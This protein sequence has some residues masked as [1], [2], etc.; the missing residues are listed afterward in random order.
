M[1]AKQ[2]DIL[3]N[4]QQKIFW[5][6]QRM[7]PLML[8]WWMALVL[9]G[10]VTTPV[11]QAPA[12][13]H[14]THG[15][16]RVSLPLNH[17]A[18]VLRLRSVKGGEEYKL[19]HQPDQGPFAFGLWIPAGEYEVAGLLNP[20]GSKYLSTEVRP[21]RLTDLGAL[22]WLQIGG[23]ES[24]LL[25]IQHP[26]AVAETQR[27]V[28]QLRPYL[29]ASQSIAWMPRVPPK[30]EKSQMA[31][32][33][34]GLIAD[35]LMQYQRHVNMPPLNQQL[36]ESK[37]IEEFFRRAVAL[38]P[39]KADEPATDADSNLYY[40]ADLG[41]IRV[42]RRDGQWTSIDTGTLQSITAVEASGR[43]LVAGT[44]QGEIR[45]SDNGQAWRVLSKFG[46]SEAILDID[47][48]NNRWLVVTARLTP[49]PMSP[50]DQW[51]DQVKVYT[52]TQDDP[53]ELTLLREIEL[54]EKAMFAFGMG[55]RGQ[56]A[57]NAYY[58]N[59]QSE[60]LKLDL[61]TLQWSAIGLAHRI[62]GYNVSPKTGVLTAYR[63]QGAFSKLSVSNDHGATWRS[64]DTP[65]Y[66]IYDVYFESPSKGVATRW[67]SGA[68]TATIEFMEYLAVENRWE[69]THEAPSGCVRIL[70]DANNVQ[71]F[72]VTSGNS[73][74][75]Y[76][77]GK[78]MAEFAVY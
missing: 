39:P 25:P 55:V 50:A 19:I 7:K 23:Y 9:T 27:A 75:T 38:M 22:I 53:T 2:H 24:V 57:G 63:N 56:H 30:P 16:V 68:F 46:S 26:E 21:G 36:K 6:G 43:R 62:S 58:I 18:D 48:I 41:Q 59:R 49:L 52:S 15:F 3:T 64:A 66:T 78:W 20:D 73:I 5:G 72:C 11:T 60:L 1:G 44:A 67:S 61:D 69:K 32:T 17:S 12:Q 65:P 34:M 47:R 37:T 14:A 45:V 51:A 8:A 28:E 29:T 54:P 33:G 71:R 10:C 13:L 70:R 77:D 42:R 76:T 31:P 35:L 74:L 40:G 4:M